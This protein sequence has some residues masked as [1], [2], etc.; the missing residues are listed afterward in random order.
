MKPMENSTGEVARA[1][2]TSFAFGFDERTILGSLEGLY[3]QQREGLVA[4]LDDATAGGKPIDW[5]GLAKG[6]HDIAGTAA[7]FGDERLAET[8]RNIEQAIR[9]YADEAKRF[10]AMR[11][12]WHLYRHAA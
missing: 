2:D 12:E 11:E 6:S 10:A 3:R 4:R 9:H 8:S 7:L 1:N 5:Q